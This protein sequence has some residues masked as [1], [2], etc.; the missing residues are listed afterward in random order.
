VAVAVVEIPGATF[1]R[2]QGLAN[3][4]F[5]KLVCGEGRELFALCQSMPGRDVEVPWHPPASTTKS[6]LGS[7]FDTLV[8]GILK[9]ASC[10]YSTAIDA[11]LSTE[12]SRYLFARQ[13]RSEQIAKGAFTT[14]DMQML[15]GIDVHVQSYADLSGSLTTSPA[16][17]SDA[18]P[19]VKAIDA[20]RGE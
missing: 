11:A 8:R 20:W 19:T 3:Q 1:V 18:T 16:S 13:K 14:A 10:T 17:P 7:D 9:S 2:R 15:D 4:A 6:A 5:T 12:G